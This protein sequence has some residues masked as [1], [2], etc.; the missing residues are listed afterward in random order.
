MTDEADGRGESPEGAGTRSGVGVRAMTGAD[1]PAVRRI[2][3]E[4]IATGTAT[5][6]TEVPDTAHLDA[7]WLPAH[8]WVAEVDG[9]VAGWA[10]V[11]PVSARACYA[12]VGE[13]S[14]YVAASAR[15]RGVGRVL[16]AHQV[17]EA[18]A[19]GLWTLQAT[20]FATNAASLALHRSG[21]FRT[22]G[23]RERIARLGGAWHDTV[24]L[25]RRSPVAGG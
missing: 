9:S 25:E 17:A 3:A 13:T 4:G 23:V 8:R 10:T 2:Y 19:G 12:G 14:L 11:T 6:T 7:T 16:L 5:F 15:G 20:V 21:G 24:L 18:D 22:V 1:W